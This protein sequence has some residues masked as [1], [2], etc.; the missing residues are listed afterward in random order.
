[1]RRSEQ[2]CAPQCALLRR[3]A[4]YRLGATPDG[5]MGGSHRA[6]PY[7]P[8]DLRWLVHAQLACDDRPSAGPTAAA[9]GG[10][11]DHGQRARRKW[12]WG[13]IAKRVSV[14]TA[15][16][17]SY[18]RFAAAHSPTGLTVLGPNGMLTEW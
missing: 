1:M 5:L 4:A 14:R 16:R 17:E 12:E 8:T 3:T 9:A 6:V 7:T 13:W 11:C 10:Q 2:Q 18:A 15:E